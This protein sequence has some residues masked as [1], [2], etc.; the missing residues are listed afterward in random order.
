MCLFCG[1]DLVD[2]YVFAIG[3]KED[4]VPVRNVHPV[5]F[6]FHRESLDISHCVRVVCQTIDM[7]AD[8]PEILIR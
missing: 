1:H 7:L 2:D 3:I 4:G 8:D 5:P 6:P